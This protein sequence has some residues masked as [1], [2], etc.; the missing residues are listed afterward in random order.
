MPRRNTEWTVAL[1]GD[2]LHDADDGA[3]LTVTG[4]LRVIRHAAVVVNGVRV[5]AWV[6]VRVTEG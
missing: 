3:K 1:K 5:G 2:R 6:E 4:R